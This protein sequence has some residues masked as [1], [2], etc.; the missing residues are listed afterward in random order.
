MKKKV[1]LENIE[2]EED[3]DLIKGN[4][5]EIDEIKFVNVDAKDNSITATLKKQITDQKIKEGIKTVSDCHVE[6]IYDL[7]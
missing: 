3:L 7:D 6:K 2:S 5:K 4:L 1:Y